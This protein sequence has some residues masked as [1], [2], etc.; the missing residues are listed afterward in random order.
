MQDLKL[1]LS[2]DQVNLVLEGLGNLPFAR[3]HL[4]IAQIQRQATE[5]LDRGDSRVGPQEPEAVA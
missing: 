3:V 1:S 2:L 4:L 5:Q